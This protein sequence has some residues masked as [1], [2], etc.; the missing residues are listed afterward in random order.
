[1][2]DSGQ[3]ATATVVAG[4]LRAETLSVGSIDV[5]S[6]LGALGTDIATCRKEASDAIAA[7]TKSTSDATN[8]MQETAKEM[9]TSIDELGKT[10][11]ALTKALK[12]VTDEGLDDRVKTLE[13]VPPT[14]QVLKTPNIL[15]FNSAMVPAP[16]THHT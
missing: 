15:P 16:R 2:I 1:M 9:Q 12:A 5:G 13:S 11:A 3:H 14:R 7:L 4:G 6:T 8:K 10:V